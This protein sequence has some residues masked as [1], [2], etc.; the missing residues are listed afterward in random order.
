MFGF[1]AVTLTIPDVNEPNWASNPV[2]TIVSEEEDR[3]KKDK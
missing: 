1:R 2:E 3:K